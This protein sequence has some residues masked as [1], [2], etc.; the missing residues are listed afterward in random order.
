MKISRMYLGYNYVSNNMK[1]LINVFFKKDQNNNVRKLWP[2]RMWLR[3]E[4]ITKVRRMLF[5]HKEMIN[6]GKLR[7]RY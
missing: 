1:I 5:I 6:V 3:Y 4:N 2:R 7:P